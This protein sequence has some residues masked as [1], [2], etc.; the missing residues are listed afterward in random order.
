MRGKFSQ[1]TIP[2]AFGMVYG[3]AAFI[4]CLDVIAANPQAVSSLSLVI[5]LFSTGM[6][7]GN[8]VM[9]FWSI[10]DPDGMLRFIRHW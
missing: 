5:F 1:F 7:I 10:M 2:L 6:F 8:V 4:I 9:F 3:L